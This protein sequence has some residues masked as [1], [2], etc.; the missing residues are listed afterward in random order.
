MFHFDSETC[1]IKMHRGDT[2]SKWIHA[3]RG[4][5]EAWTAADR[6]LFTVRSQ[7]GNEI[8]MQRIYRLDD[9]W[10]AGNGWFLMEF[11]N[12][13]TDDWE[14]GSYSTE[15]RFNVDPLWKGGTAPEGRCVDALF[16]GDEMV[17]GSIVRTVVQSTMTLDDVYGGI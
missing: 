3:E 8:V 15:W 6:C 4:S 13:D 16:T 7:S 14:N 17:E 1:E 11:H 10:G 12:D 9:Q 5:G 2:G